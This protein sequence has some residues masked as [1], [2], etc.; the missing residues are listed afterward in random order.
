MS[1]SARD[2]EPGSNGAVA[3]QPGKLRSLWDM[4]QLHADSFFEAIRILTIWANPDRPEAKYSADWRQKQIEQIERFQ[5]SLLD[6]GFIASTASLKKLAIEFRND[7][8]TAASY[9]QP[10]EEA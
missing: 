7:E 4:K 5:R 6:I 9:K 3:W 1:A 8:A 10:S 2:C